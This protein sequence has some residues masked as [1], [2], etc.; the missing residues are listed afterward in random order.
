ME[1]STVTVDSAGTCAERALARSN[2]TSVIDGAGVSVVA[3][4]AVGGRLGHTGACAWL[5][6]GEFTLP[7]WRAVDDGLRGQVAEAL[8]AGQRAIAEVSVLVN[9][10]VLI[11][12]AC[13]L[14][15]WRPEAGPL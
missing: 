5:A 4:R 14:R 9:H 6:G 11:G 8:K 10:A 12:V 15:V 7:R 2:V 13:A 1:D 3:P